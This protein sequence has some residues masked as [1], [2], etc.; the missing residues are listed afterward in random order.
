MSPDGS[1]VDPVEWADRLD[2][3]DEHGTGVRRDTLMEA[4]M[5]V[6]HAVVRL[7]DMYVDLDGIADDLGLY[8]DDVH[9]GLR[10][11]QSETAKMLVWMRELVEALQALEQDAIEAEW[12]A[13]GR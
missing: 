3:G 7:E 8:P 6:Q 13:R 9:R 12:K 11:H 1:D 5:D 10:K 2:P 4:R